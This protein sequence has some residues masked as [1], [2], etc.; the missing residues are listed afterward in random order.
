MDKLND[1][2]LRVFAIA[3]GQTYVTD[4]YSLYSSDASKRQKTIDRL[5]AH[6]DFAVELK[7]MVIIGGIRG[8]IEA[9]SGEDWQTEAEK[10]L[11]AI[12]TCAEYA[13]RANVVL[14]LEPINRYETN[15]VNTIEQGLEMIQKLG[16]SNLKLLPD[17]FH[18][19]IEEK[20]ISNSLMKA[21]SSIG[22]VHFADSNRLAPGWGH[23]DFAGVLSV[24]EIIGYADP[25]GVEVLPKPSDRA[26]A[27]QAIHF[28]RMLAKSRK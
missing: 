22:Y 5:K 25:I 13:K 7:S 12:A 26:S 10:G 4:G 9:A 11:E 17:T 2:G 8:K 18:M 27:E 15:V 21:R 1:F 20:S 24:L 14:L 19:N 16:N 3:T 23:F 28:L 6:I